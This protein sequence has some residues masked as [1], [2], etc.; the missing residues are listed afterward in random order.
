MEQN[1]L[2]NIMKDYL[3]VR[4]K[5]RWFYLQNKLNDK[6]NILNP[7]HFSG[8]LVRG[9]VQRV[10][11]EKVKQEGQKGRFYKNIVSIGT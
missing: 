10:L 1:H 3:T 9:L 4:E 11:S 2:K 6:K 5:N 8:K 7:G